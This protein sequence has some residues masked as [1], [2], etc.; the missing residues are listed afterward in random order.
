MIGNL[1]NNA[2]KYNR[3]KGAIFLCVTVEGKDLVVAVRDTGIGIKKATLGQVFDLFTQ[4]QNGSAQQ[5]GGLGIGLSVVKEWP[6]CMVDLSQRLCQVG[7]G[8]M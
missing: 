2:A 7:G 3:A 1:L 6:R 5:N 4:G 8:R